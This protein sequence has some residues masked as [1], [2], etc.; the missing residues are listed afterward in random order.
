MNYGGWINNRL[1]PAT[2][3]YYRLCAVDRWNN[4]GPLSAPFAATTLR[5]DQKNMA[6]LRVEC[7]RAILVSPISPQNF[8]N[9]LFRTSCEPD[10]R[11][12]EV[13]RSTAA[14]FEPDASTRIGIADADALVKASRPMA[15]CPSTTAQVITIT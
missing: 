15:M 7:L 11:R 5:S 2:T 10:V 12:Y 14:G 13:H 6:P 8:V 9:L 4:Q 1:E 3:Y